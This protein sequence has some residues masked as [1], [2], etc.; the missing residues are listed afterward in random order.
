MSKKHFSLAIKQEVYDRA[1]GRCEYCKCPHFF[2]TE[3]YTI[4]HIYP[5]S[6]GGSD[7]LDN[8][9]FS[10]FGCN[11]YKATKT[12]ILDELSMQMWPVFNPRIMSWQ[13]HFVWDVSFTEIL[14]L[15]AIGRATI[16]ALRLNRKQVVNLRFALIAIGEHPPEIVKH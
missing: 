11:L 16:E 15:T 10:C 1:A 8:L 12:L 4:E 2:S 13:E 3:P 5:K 14:G 6:K 7:E 9:A